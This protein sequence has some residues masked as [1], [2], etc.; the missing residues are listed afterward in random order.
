M[1]KSLL[2]TALLMGSVLSA[3]AFW[4]PTPVLTSE[5][6]EDGK[7]VVDWSYDSS[8][9]PCSY[10]Q[11]IVYKMHKAPADEKFCLAK[12]GFD[13]LEDSKGTMTKSENRGML[14]DY[15]PDN[16]GWWVRN[17]MY[18]KGAMG[19]DTFF[20]FS[21]SDNSDIF[22]GAYM[23][24]P[25]YDLSKLSDKTIEVKAD[26]ANEAVSV[27]G[28]FCLW[29]WNTNWV[30]AANIDY[31]PVIG[32]DF[33]YDDINSTNWRTKTENIIFPNVADFTDPDAIDE[34]NGIQHSRSRVMFYGVGYSSYW[35][36]NFS[37][38]VNMKKDETVDYGAAI[39][40][41]E[42][43]SFTI[44]TTGDTEN[45][46]VYAYEVRAVREDYDEYRSRNYIRAI[47]YPYA[48]AKKVIGE[49]AG[50]E[51]VIATT[52]GSDI[53]I[54]AADGCIIIAGAEGLD[55][56]VF[57]TMGRCVYNG[58]A[59]NAISLPAGL[60]IVKAGDKTAKVIL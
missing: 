7:V 11:V 29:A 15:L 33:H 30:D 49:T 8:E 14:W 5:K 42:G 6:I 18:M 9:E 52:P 47:N 32:N 2:L 35:I 50:I 4:L 56:Q 26:L 36:D 25:D 12:S 28:G 58:T 22:G 45:D 59:D 1:K 40:K 51:D 48:Y 23:V 54:S 60:Y 57:D 43:N 38:S 10:F 41:V 39:H 53:A 16:P 27:S 21:G 3:K 44:D 20:Y 24:S 17:P 34:V 46:Y 31:K 55:A 19:I 37:V 13:W